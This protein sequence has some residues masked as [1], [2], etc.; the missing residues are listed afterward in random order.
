MRQSAHSDLQLVPVREQ[1]IPSLAHSIV[2]WCGLDASIRGEKKKPQTK[3]A[4]KTLGK[5]HEEGEN[6]HDLPVQDAGSASFLH[7]VKLFAEG[8][9]FTPLPSW[10]YS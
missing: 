4:P 1:P 6:K 8:N 2:P 10:N 7:A 5:R 9:N 3:K